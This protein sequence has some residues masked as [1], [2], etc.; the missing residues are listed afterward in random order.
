M[1]KKY[2]A[3]NEIKDDTGIKK[4]GETP[5]SS[6]AAYLFKG[7]CKRI[8]ENLKYDL[9]L[10]ETEEGLP[11]MDEMNLAQAKLDKS[12]KRNG[13]TVLSGIKDLDSVTA[14]TPYDKGPGISRQQLD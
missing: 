2:T 14:L 3:F 12:M 5:I 4:L 11:S 10:E 1:T 8:T 9:F 13:R 7:Y 6:E